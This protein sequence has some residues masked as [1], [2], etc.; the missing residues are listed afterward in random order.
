LD[1]SP[2]FRNHTPSTFSVAGPFSVHT[3]E[4]EKRLSQRRKDSDAEVP[5]FTNLLSRLLKFKTGRKQHM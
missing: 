4:G 1:P 3:Q 5:G 2:G